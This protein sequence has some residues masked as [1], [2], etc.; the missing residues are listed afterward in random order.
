VNNST[1]RSTDK[2][3]CGENSSIPK[4]QL[5]RAVSQITTLSEQISALE[6]LKEEAKRS[7]PEILT[8]YIKTIPLNDIYEVLSEV[9]W[10]DRTMAGVVRTV[11]SRVIGRGSFIPLHITVSIETTCQD[12]GDPC[13]LDRHCAS[14]SNHDELHSV[15]YKK[16][17]R[18]KKCEATYKDREKSYQEK[19]QKEDDIR[20][21]E[22][23]RLKSLPYSQYLQTDHW[24]NIAYQAKRKAGFRCQMC[25]SSGL[26]NAHHRTYERR[27]EEW[28][29]DIT[30][31]CEA[32]HEHFHNVIKEDV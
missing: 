22:V 17:K 28:L 8:S 13:I 15:R 25:N 14:W 18:C 23:L 31:V 19:Q 21:A 27:G 10:S 29:T 6:A 20:K 3:V 30:V 11:Y 4:Q 7:L 26:L 5:D 24:K 9:Y 32:C 2:S 12:C 1:S 16:W